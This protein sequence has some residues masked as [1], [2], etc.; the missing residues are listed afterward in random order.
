MPLNI[1]GKSMPSPVWYRILYEVLGKVIIRVRQY[2]L[3]IYREGRAFEASKRF[4][5]AGN[6]GTAEMLFVNP[7][8]SGVDAYIIDI[9]WTQGA[10]IDIDIYQDPEISSYGS[11]VPWITK[12]VGSQENPKCRVYTGGSYG[13]S[14]KKMEL[15]GYGGSKNFA[16][17]GQAA[18]GAGIIVDEG[19]SLL[20][21]LTNNGTSNVKASIRISWYEE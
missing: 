18:I 11:E 2:I 1:L 9:E 6:G 12:K 4:S 3:D 21:K 19:H 20:I 8:G 16:S 17:G 14:S 10:E 15:L 7:E 5:L 13:S